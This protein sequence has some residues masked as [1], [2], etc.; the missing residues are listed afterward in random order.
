MK[1]RASRL[2]AEGKLRDALEM[3]RRVLEE[4]PGQL[5]CQTKVG[6]IHR[7]LGASGEAVAAYEGVARR[8]AEDG[9]LLKAI[10]VC[11]LILT[12]DPDHTSTQAML[13]DLYVRRRAGT[14]AEV[15]ALPVSR[16]GAIPPSAEVSARA[17]WPAP[18]SGPSEVAIPEMRNILSAWPTSQPVLL[19]AAEEGDGSGRAPLAGSPG[20]WPDPCGADSA[21]PGL[22]LRSTDDGVE[23]ADLAAARDPELEVEA[24][25]AV[26]VEDTVELIDIA[27]AFPVEEETFA[28]RVDLS[29]VG[30]EEADADPGRAPT[31]LIPL[32]S[33]LPK[34]AFVEILVRMKMLVAR[35]GEVIIREGEDGDAFYVV[36]S[37]I[38]SVSRKD[39]HGRE[40]RL[41]H[42]GE[43][44]FFGEMALLQ[45]GI[46]TA[47]VRVEED[48]QI[49]E[50]SR[51][52]LE[53]VITQYPTVATAVRNFY[54]QRLLATA[55][56]THPLFAPFEKSE[57]RALMEQ[58]KSRSFAPGE[59]IL[60]EGKKGN[61]LYLL[62]HG[63]VEVS[64]KVDGH[65]R[66]LAELSSGDLFGEMS[67]LTGQPTNG[68]VTALE[69]AFVLRLSKKRFDELILSNGAVLD[70]IAHL[71][72]ARAEH[73][74][75]LLG[76]QLDARGAVLV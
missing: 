1:D 69:D 3:Y 19:D 76:Q 65:R 73:N 25:A 27:E 45:D 9:L 11:K 23:T 13:A 29:A 5:S 70:L 36:A 52:L 24:S 50:I 35:R 57:R 31:P 61:G 40:V 47:T 8:Y 6:D 62:L 38:V 53:E 74:D 41:A 64:K 48:A 21:G 66:V 33:E 55:F 4:D 51:E 68:T 44:A 49:F 54:R 59:V 28:G 20:L 39:E 56:A 43:G 12:L 32:F 60:E 42:L 17:A 34:K 26:P 22:E 14:T 30:D 63:R 18:S 58:F 15:P 75:A 7:R 72:E 10:A 37:G 2:Y 16:A 71:S 67:L 46:R